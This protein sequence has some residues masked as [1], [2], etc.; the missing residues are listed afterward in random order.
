MRWIIQKQIQGDPRLNYDPKRGAVKSALVVWGPYLW[1]NGNT[2]RKSDGLVWKEEDF[3]NPMH[4]HTHPG[5]SA[6]QKVAEMLLKFFET[7]SAARRWFVS[8][9]AQASN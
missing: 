9:S 7:D 4:D 2:P 1:A 6:K 8:A 3:I 5:E